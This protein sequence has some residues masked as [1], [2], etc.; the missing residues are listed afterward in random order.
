M[1][2]SRELKELEHVTEGQWQINGDSKKGQWRGPM[3]APPDAA[4]NLELEIL[5][6]AIHEVP[7]RQLHAIGDFISNL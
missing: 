1:R 2:K 5:G 4:Q 3:A 7:I 6:S